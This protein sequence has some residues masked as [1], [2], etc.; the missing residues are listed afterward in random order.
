MSIPND[1]I[2]IK[3]KDG[4]FKYFKD[5]QLF[6]VQEIEDKFRLNGKVGSNLQVQKEKI[7]PIQRHP[8]DLPKDEKKEIELEKE[9]TDSFAMAMKK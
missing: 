5:G 2:L 7:A 1:Y 3:D 6:S 9:E 8:L 4:V